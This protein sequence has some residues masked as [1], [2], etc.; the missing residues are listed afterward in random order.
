MSDEQPWYKDGL[1]F[2][3]TQCG[4]CCTGAPGV[5][6]VDDEELQAI[7]DHLGKSIGEVRLFHTRLV[8][9]RVTLK[10]SANGDCTFF[11]GV[12]RRCTIYAAR[13]KQCRSWPFWNSNISTPKDWQEM[14]A[15]CPGA[16]H[17]AFVRLEDI[18]CQ[19]EMIDI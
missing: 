10:D 6:W 4:N 14:Q 16:G 18:Q 8:G 13:P 12:E 19:A 15:D 11:D 9:R 5:V 3:C 2:E 17:G 7:A 1:Q